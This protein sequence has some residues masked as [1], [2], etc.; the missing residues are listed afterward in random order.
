[1]FWELTVYITMFPILILGR[2][3]TQEREHQN[4]SS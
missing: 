3:M 4:L 1:M 2:K